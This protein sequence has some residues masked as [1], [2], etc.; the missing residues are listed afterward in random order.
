MT[1]DIPMET[2]RVLL[3]DDEPAFQRLGGNFLRGLGHEVQI[4]GDGT[5]ATEPHLDAS[6]FKRLRIRALQYHPS[7][8]ATP[9]ESKRAQ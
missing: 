9:R 1:T 3:V 6:A 5:Q 7:S 2:G 8:S 4:A